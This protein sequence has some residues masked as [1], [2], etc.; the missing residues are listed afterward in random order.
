LSY[1]ILRAYSGAQVYA[2][3]TSKNSDG[4]LLASIDVMTRGA[5]Q[6]CLWT[7]ITP[8][9]LVF[10]LVKGSAL[11]DKDELTI[12]R[13]AKL[14]MI[15]QSRALIRI[16]YGL[17]KLLWWQKIPLYHIEAQPKSLD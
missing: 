8:V 10:G 14:G 12:A 13:S 5:A 11:A 7:I 16:A 9:M 3:A 15:R 4:P 6:A 1:Q 17:G 2:A